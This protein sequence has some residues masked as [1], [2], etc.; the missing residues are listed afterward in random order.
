[1]TVSTGRSPPVRRSAGPAQSYPNSLNPSSCAI[2]EQ[3]ADQAPPDGVVRIAISRTHHQ[4]D[5]AV[6][7]GL[8]RS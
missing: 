4:R 5:F 3:I 1:L 7:A 6:C 2:A 8:A